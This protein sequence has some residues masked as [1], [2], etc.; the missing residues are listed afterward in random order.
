MQIDAPLPD[1]RINNEF[2]KS[3]WCHACVDIIQGKGHTQSAWRCQI[4]GDSYCIL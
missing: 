1:C 2:I 4:S 3:Q